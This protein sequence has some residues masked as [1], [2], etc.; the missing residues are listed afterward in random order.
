MG[1]IKKKKKKNLPCLLNFFA[2]TVKFAKNFVL[3]S[4][5]IGA[6]KVQLQSLGLYLFQNLEVFLNSL[7]GLEIPIA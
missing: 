5:H 7:K 4:P 2:N 1:R 3:F 6:D